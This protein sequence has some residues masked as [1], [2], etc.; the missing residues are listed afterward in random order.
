MIKGKINSKSSLK[1]KS[2]VSNFMKG[3]DGRSAYEV[4]LDNGFI[5]TEEEWLASLKG[6]QG[7]QGP[8]GPQGPAGEKQDLSNYYNK[9]EID[10]MIGDIESVLNEVV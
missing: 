7:I 8:E 9:N 5:G 1:G 4:A 3:D 6:E 2:V 10:T